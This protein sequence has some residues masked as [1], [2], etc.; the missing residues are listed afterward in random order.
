MLL[1][2]CD[3][4]QPTADEE[5]HSDNDSVKVRIKLKGRRSESSASSG[6]R[7]VKKLSKKLFNEE[8]EDEEE[9]CNSYFRGRDLAGQG[10]I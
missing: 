3:A 5:V 8:D 1:C 4:G 10:W 7:N 6:R 2:V 9:V